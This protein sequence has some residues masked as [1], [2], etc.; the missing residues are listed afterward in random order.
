MNVKPHQNM[1][2]I[3]IDVDAWRRRIRDDTFAHYHH[4]MGVALLRTEPM[5][6]AAAFERALTI[7]PDD[8]AAGYGLVS[9]LRAA[10]RLA[11]A[12]NVDERLRKRNPEYWS[13]G[14]FTMGH[15]AREADHWGDAQALYREV[16]DAQ[17]NHE[18]ARDCLG[19]CLAQAGNW[20]EAQAIYDAIAPRSDWRDAER[21]AS[22]HVSLGTLLLTKGDAIHFELEIRRGLAIDPDNYIGLKNLGIF[23]VQKN[24]P[25][26]W[27]EALAMLN[28]AHKLLPGS[29]EIIHW[30]CHLL[31]AMGHVSRGERLLQELIASGRA[32]A[33]DRFLLA[34]SLIAARRYMEAED[35]AREI[36]SVSPHEHFG[37]VALGEVHM[38]TG[39]CETAMA[40]LQSAI[41][42]VRGTV[43]NFPTIP[44]L[45]AFAAWTLGR[46]NEAEA[47]AEWALR[48]ARTD[49]AL[50]VLGLVRYRQGR[51]DD[52]LKLLTRAR[53]AAP[54]KAWP[55]I[56][57]A[58]VLYDM[59]RE[60]EG[61][62]A[63]IQGHQ[64]Q[65]TCVGF[66]IEQHGWMRVALEA[67]ASRLGLNLSP[68]EL[69][70]EAFSPGV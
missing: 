28:R 50:A 63:L 15:G 26:V 46:F 40:E 54:L 38:A 51:V 44:A 23:L 64:A 6:A 57:Q 52:A 8:P 3:K 14:A 68:Q 2:G 32:T 60:A 11:E 20:E 5:A 4:E 62:A 47:D 21:I 7:L 41:D 34:M 36:L 66:Q 39:N 58:A 70:N 49:R 16:V 42:L 65:P 37:Y 69:E 53:E 45:R 18:E 55:F 35:V 17:P 13:N 29:L 22:G 10:G 19:L 24:L 25:H 56:C 61:D 9:A 48:L 30:L 12:A 33:Y 1:D 27:S 43:H 67:H 31:L 59:G